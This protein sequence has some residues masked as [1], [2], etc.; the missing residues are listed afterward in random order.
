MGRKTASLFI[1]LIVISL[2]SGCRKEETVDYAALEKTAALHL[3]QTFEALPT[4]TNTFTPLPTNTPLP[5]ATDTPEPAQDDMIISR[6]AADGST[7]SFV[8]SLSDNPEDQYMISREA[9]GGA[10]DLMITRSGNPEDQYMISRSAP[11]ENTAVPEPTATVY[12][13][14]KADFISALPSPNQF[15]PNQHFYLTWQIKNIGTSTWSGKYRFY[16]SDGVQ[17]ADQNSYEIT[18][19][20]EPG[21]ILT[22]T[23]PATAPGTLGTYKTVWT[24]ENPDGIPFY[25]LNFIT[26]VGEQTFITNV[27]ELYPSAT[28]SAL[29]WMCSDAERSL[30]Q[31][32][33]CTDFCTAP[34]VQQMQ[35]DGQ[36][37]Y[38]Y[39][40]SVD[41]GE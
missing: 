9:D 6:G 41:Y 31:G 24:L 2:F 4:A 3:T 27:P 18:Q 20:V 29:S 1:I 10:D 16:F 39:G 33:G 32:D 34:V 12:F 25:Y 28:P 22:V 13:P 14:D 15:I 23:M 26:I 5:T 17:I 8:I 7:D 35:E 30:V 11:A 21:G 38:A 40:E 37:C 36:S 19:I